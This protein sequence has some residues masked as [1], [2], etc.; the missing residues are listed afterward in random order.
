MV[1]NKNHEGYTDLTAYKA[2]K[3]IEN[4]EK[5][6]YLNRY[7]QVCMSIDRITKSIIA[8]RN[9]SA[10]PVINYDGMPRAKVHHDLSEQFSLLDEKQKKVRELTVEK[11]NIKKEILGKAEKLENDKE[12]D[13]ILLRYIDLM[14]WENIADIMGYTFQHV[15][16]IHA[17]ALRNF[18][19]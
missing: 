15:H 19:I 9:R 4:E 8:L 12:Y 16:R 11:E 14:K 17:S 3:K 13:V 10:T 7:K 18:E 6:E 5:K 1:D 2:I